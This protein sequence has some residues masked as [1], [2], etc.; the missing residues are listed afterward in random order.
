MVA[1]AAVMPPSRFPSNLDAALHPTAQYAIAS[2]V[3]DP[4]FLDSRLNRGVPCSS[5]ALG[6]RVQRGPGQA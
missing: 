2:T 6:G 5:S 1:A 3:L 4:E